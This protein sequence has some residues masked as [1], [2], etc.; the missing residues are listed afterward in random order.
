MN[1]QNKGNSNLDS[2]DSPVSGCLKI[3]H[4]CILNNTFTL[5]NWCFKRRFNED[6]II[7]MVLP[8]RFLDH[9]FQLPKHSLNCESL[10]YEVVTSWPSGLGNYFICKRFAVQTLLW[11]LEFVIQI[12]PQHNTIT[13]WNLVQSWSISWT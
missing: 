9:K 12:N 13:V 4:H 11:S 6:F 8:S 10:A 1:W 3:L 7:P 2:L 5:Q